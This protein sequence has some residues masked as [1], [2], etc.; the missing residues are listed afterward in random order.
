MNRRYSLVFALALSPL[1]LAACRGRSADGQAVTEETREAVQAAKDYSQNQMRDYQDNTETALK[2]FDRK[3]E[4][5]RVRAESSAANAR[6]EIRAKI[7]ELREKKTAAQLKLD[8]LKSSTKDA[9]GD[10]KEGMDGAMDDLED[11]YKDAASRFK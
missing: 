9:W 10:V 1:L 3:I 5:L 2:G 11:S 8:E 4:E 6:G 7:T